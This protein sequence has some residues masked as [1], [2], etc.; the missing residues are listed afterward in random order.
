MELFG[1]SSRDVVRPSLIVAVLFLLIGSEAQATDLTDNIL[2]QIDKIAAHAESLR[3]ESTIVGI[4]AIAIA[5]IGGVTSVF[6]TTESRISRFTTTTLGILIVVLIATKEQFFP[7]SRAELNRQAITA[8]NLISEVRLNLKVAGSEMDL[9]TSMALLQM[10][11]EYWTTQAERT[12]Y[13]P[14]ILP[15]ASAIAEIVPCGQFLVSDQFN[16]Y[17]GIGEARTPFM[18]K[19]IASEN[20]VKGAAEDYAEYLRQKINATPRELKYLDL[21]SR[22]QSLLRLKG[23][24]IETPIM[25]IDPTTGKQAQWTQSSL[26]LSIPKI[27]DDR[28]REV[29][30]TFIRQMRHETSIGKF[31]MDISPR[32]LARQKALDAAVKEYSQFLI[33]SIN[34]KEYELKALDLSTRLG[35]LVKPLDSANGLYSETPT[36][37]HKSYQGISEALDEKLKNAFMIYILDYRQKIASK[38]IAEPAPQ[39]NPTEESKHSDPQAITDSESPQSRTA[40]AAKPRKINA[41]QSLTDKPIL[42]KQEPQNPKP[43][44][45]PSIAAPQTAQATPLDKPQ[46]KPQEKPQAKQVAPTPKP[47]EIEPP[48]S[49]L[50]EQAQSPDSP[51]ESPVNNTDTV[52]TTDQTTPQVA[53]SKEASEAEVSEIDAWAKTINDPVVI[54]ALSELDLTFGNMDTETNENDDSNSS[55]ANSFTPEER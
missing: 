24:S 11:M 47:I 42:Q 40:K 15:I 46:E 28:M 9:D 14:V 37:T 3:Q 52:T 22:L 26:S 49:H 23:K 34:A 32:A 30:T 6:K 31:K 36:I 54:E 7:S 27:A 16:C 2:E 55:E 4:I 19:R 25:K 44:I 41:K 38:E 33:N 13:Q 53:K 5:A 12:A 18:S 17:Q 39:E 43:D 10:L 1:Q 21:E 20:A 29:L 50:T 51:A 8:E 45:S 48:A 35:D